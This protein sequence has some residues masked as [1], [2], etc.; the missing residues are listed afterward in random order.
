MMASQAM[1]SQIDI[2]PRI[3]R[4][5][6]LIRVRRIT[7]DNI[8]A[9]IWSCTHA[10]NEVWKSIQTYGF[11]DWWI[12]N[13]R[14]IANDKSKSWF[15]IDD[16][17]PCLYQHSIIAAYLCHNKLIN[18]EK[19]VKNIIQHDNQLYYNLLYTLVG[20]S[21]VKMNDR[22]E[23]DKY[24][25]VHQETGEV[26]RR[27]M[28]DVSGYMICPIDEPECFVSYERWYDYDLFK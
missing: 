26:R 2:L 18:K 12:D 3:P 5:N 8:D 11:I 22:N 1:Q 23:L 7:K 10:E 16:N 13:A 19:T 14:Q 9:L 4:E 17:I 24:A 21:L 28:I 15:I 6:R 20:P 25:V 27:M